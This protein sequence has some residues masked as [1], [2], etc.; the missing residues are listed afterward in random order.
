MFEEALQDVINGHT[1]LIY[2]DVTAIKVILFILAVVIW[3]GGRNCFTSASMQVCKYASMQ[4]CKYA[5]MH[6]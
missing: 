4:V 1:R 2:Y 5:S 6:V 3:G